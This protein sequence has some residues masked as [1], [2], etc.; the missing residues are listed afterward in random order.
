MK[1]ERVDIVRGSYDA[2][3]ALANHTPS[4]INDHTIY[5]IYNENKTEGALYMG[6]IPYIKIGGGQSN[7]SIA[8]NEDTNTLGYYENDIWYPIV[9][10]SPGGQTGEANKIHIIDADELFN[11]GNVEDALKELQQLFQNNNIEITNL[12]DQKVDKV[13]GKGLSSNDF[14]T[15]EKQKLESLKLINPIQKTEEMTQ[16][17]GIDDNGQLWAMYNTNQDIFYSYE[18]A[19]E[20]ASTN[21][22]AYIGQSITVIDSVLDTVTVYVISNSNM[23]LS[24]VGE[25]SSIK[26][27]NLIE[28]KPKINGITLI[29]DKSSED[30]NLDLASITN[31]D[32]EAILS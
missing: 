24:P 30:L 1:I 10:I 3:K 13:E 7:I 18:E 19:V 22:L 28:N 25:S 12:I 29:G 5:F 2:Y 6:N 21:P 31:S 20:Y 14:T 8:F 17:V 23:E 4:L 32:I 15:L 26:D 11:A 9:K 27:Y 16:Q